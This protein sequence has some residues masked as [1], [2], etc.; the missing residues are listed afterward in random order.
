MTTRS[1]ES[2]GVLIYDPV[3][4]NRNVTRASL[5]SLGFRNVELAP[6]VEILAKQL[7]EHA[8]DLLLAEVTGTETEICQFVQA[9]RQGEYGGNPFMVIIVTTWRRDGTIVSKVINSGAD[10]LVARP[11]STSMLGERINLQIDRRKGFVVTSDY[12]GPDRRRDPS[13]PGGETIEVPNSLRVRTMGDYQE[14]EA[15]RRIVYA[16]EQGKEIVNAQKIRRDSILLCTQWRVL[17]QRP[18]GTRDFFD[19][20]ARFGRI[21]LGIRRRLIEGDRSSAD[22]LCATIGNAAEAIQIARDG[23]IAGTDLTV[24]YTANLEQ[25]GMAA[26]GLG[27]IF[28]PGEADVP[29]PGE[30]EACATEGQVKAA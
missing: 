6:T 12:I 27:R 20:V 17:E 29:N 25:L 3:A 21:A 13:R 22:G 1:Y 26:I 7:K 10:D 5:H 19:T 16:I 24:D 28:A 30:A 23:G 11:L 18:Q 14:D 15:E 9:V 2:A 4:S 8:P